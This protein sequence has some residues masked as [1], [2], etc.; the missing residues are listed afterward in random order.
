MVL[1]WL[2]IVF[3]SG[4]GVKKKW[5]GLRDS[6]AKHLRSLK[7]TTGQAA[8][9]LNRY[10]FWPWANQMSFLKSHIEYAT[11]ESNVSSIDLENVEDDVNHEDVGSLSATAQDHDHA[12]Q[13]STEPGSQDTNTVEKLT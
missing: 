6:Y 13:T 3:I 1:G 7:T 4:E 12:T 2:F 9:P 10:K 5:K 8:K 11:T